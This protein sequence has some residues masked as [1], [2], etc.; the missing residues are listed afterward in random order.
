MYLDNQPPNDFLYSPRALTSVF[1]LLIHRWWS[2]PYLRWLQLGCLSSASHQGRRISSIL[3]LQAC[4]MPH[5]IP[6]PSLRCRHQGLLLDLIL[7]T[8]LVWILCVSHSLKTI[9]GWTVP[10][11]H[12]RC[13][14]IFSSLQISPR[15]WMKYFG[16]RMPGGTSPPI[17]SRSQKTCLCSILRCRRFRSI[18]TSH[19]PP[20][21]RSL[22]R[23]Q[24]IL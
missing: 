1:R 11:L 20:H 21:C 3:P 5:P 16:K 4:Q 24:L 14:P 12:I 7:S 2:I 6:H 17:P 15:Y 23:L 10:T 22:I 9:P 8:F 18:S 19:P 13:H